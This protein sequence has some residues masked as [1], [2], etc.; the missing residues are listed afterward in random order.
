LDL[1]GLAELAIVGAFLV[2]GIREARIVIAKRYT[3]VIAPRI[4]AERELAEKSATIA[5]KLPDSGYELMK[6]IELGLIKMEADMRKALES[7]GVDLT[8]DAG[9]DH[10]V[11]RLRQ[12]QDGIRRYEGNPIYQ[13][14]DS[15]GWPLLKRLPDAAVNYLEELFA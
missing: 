13:M 6:N 15:I 10:T 3:T 1:Y 7:K 8:K 2:L 5:S 12:V 4:K 14:A 11:S 9:Y